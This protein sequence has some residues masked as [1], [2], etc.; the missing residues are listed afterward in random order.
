M[1]E[2]DIAGSLDAS[3]DLCVV[4]EDIKSRVSKNVP[5]F[6]HSDGGKNAT[7]CDNGGFDADCRGAFTGEIRE[8]G[9][10]GR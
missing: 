2:Q 3:G 1:H 9:N 10:L 8:C 5:D 4:V 6:E 7:R